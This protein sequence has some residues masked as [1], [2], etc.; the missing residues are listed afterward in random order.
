[1]TL[2]GRG[3]WTIPEQNEAAQTVLREMAEFFVAIAEKRED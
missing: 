3:D 1:M 2:V